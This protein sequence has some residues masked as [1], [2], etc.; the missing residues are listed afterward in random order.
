MRHILALILHACRV[1]AQCSLVRSVDDSSPTSVVAG[2]VRGA[3]YT[4]KEPSGCSYAG[5]Q[6]SKAGLDP[7]CGSAA[8]SDCTET[9]CA[10]DG[11]LD[12][13]FNSRTY[14][15]AKGMGAASAA[16]A[17][18]RARSCDGQS[19]KDDGSPADYSCVD[20]RAGAFHLAGKSLS[21]TVDLSGSGCG[22]NAAVY[23]VSMPQNPD[24]TVC[25]DYY[26][27]ANNVCGV[28]CFEIDLMEANKV[29]FVSTVHVGDDPNGEG[30]GIA[31]YVTKREKRLRSERG[32]DCAYGPRESCTID[33]NRPFTATFS[34]SSGAQ[35]GYSLVLEQDGGQR[36]ATLG[37]QLVRYISKPGKGS[38]GSADEANEMLAKALAS[39]MTLV[40]SNCELSPP[41][42]PHPACLNERL[43]SCCSQ[44]PIRGQLYSEYSLSAAPFCTPLLSDL[45]EYAS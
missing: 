17:E 43:R 27:D 6:C 15:L 42:A 2:L 22:C 16:V 4:V 5:A 11:A 29:A 25:K 41:Q 24:A 26:C 44:L 14:V 28:P 38:V 32:D 7:Q 18:T 12:V 3:R 10:A 39:G 45:D 36:R 8:G 21:F 13:R 9:P 30:Y 31:H 19:L 37:T 23:L 34:F 20:Y 1:A 35:F 33:T 40:V